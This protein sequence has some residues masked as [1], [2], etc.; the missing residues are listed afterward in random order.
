MG[1]GTQ[2]QVFASSC[3][4]HI[5]WVIDSGASKHVTDMSTSFKT[6]IPYI[7]FESVQIADVT[8]QQIHGIR[9]I[10]CTPSLSLSSVLH[11]PYFLVN[12]IYISSIIDQSKCIITFDE[13]SCVFRRGLGE[14]LGMESSVMGCGS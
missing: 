3:R 1:K 11:V 5:D 13:N 10:E 8:S 4:H 12:L 7:H 2:A 6:Y 14:R 9:F